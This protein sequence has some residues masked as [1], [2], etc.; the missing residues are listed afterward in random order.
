MRHFESAFSQ[1]TWNH[2]QVLMVGTLLARGR[3]T[4]TAA[5]RHMGL[6]DERNF[7]TY[8]QVLNRAQWSA[9]ELSR[10]LL[11][12]LVHTFIAAGGALSFVIDETL[13]R[14]SRPPHQNPWPLS[15]PTRIEQ[16]AV[17]FYQRRAVD[18]AELDRH[19]TLDEPV[20]G[21]AGDECERTN[22]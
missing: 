20:V 5:L 8:H 16:E 6:R 2:V 21:P 22:T 14:R 12:L 1:P 10:R 18:R 7:S 9:L 15:R 11:H 17:G 4:V 19:S 3:R 13:E